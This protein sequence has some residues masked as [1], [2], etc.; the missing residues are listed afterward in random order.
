MDP[1]ATAFILRLIYYFLRT[2]YYHAVGML[3]L[4]VGP[5]VSDGDI[6]D[7]DAT[8]FTEFTELIGG[9]VGTQVCDNA[10]GKAKTVY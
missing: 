4:A 1:F 5:R 10:V 6:P 9:K 8:S 3:N 7:V 2:V